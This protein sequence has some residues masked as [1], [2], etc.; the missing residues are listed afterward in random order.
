M[1][2]VVAALATGRLRFLTYPHP[3]LTSG[4]ANVVLSMGVRTFKQG[5]WRVCVCVALWRC[6]TVR[7]GQELC[8]LTTFVTFEDQKGGDTRAVLDVSIEVEGRPSLQL[9][10]FTAGQHLGAGLYVE[11]LVAFACTWRDQF[12][13]HVRRVSLSC[14]GLNDRKRSIILLFCFCERLCCRFPSIELG[15]SCSPSGDCFSVEFQ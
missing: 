6:G 8:H 15:A 4:S 10:H 7:R 9:A 2:L 13:P 5:F 1:W 3:C 12:L 11:F 14:R